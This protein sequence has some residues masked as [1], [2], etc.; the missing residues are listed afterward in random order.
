MFPLFLLRS[1]VHQRVGELLQIDAF[2]RAAYYRSAGVRLSPILPKQFSLQRRAET[3]V[4]NDGTG[5]G[6]GY[7]PHSERGV[8]CNDGADAY[9]DALVHGAQVVSHGHGL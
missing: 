6:A 4:D 5:V 3:A 2:S 9:T 8:I 1:Y 7:Q